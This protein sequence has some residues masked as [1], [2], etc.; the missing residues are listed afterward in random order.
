M[1]NICLKEK[2]NS[3][4]INE[5]DSNDLNLDL[6]ETLKEGKWIS[7]LSTY[8]NGRKSK[9]MHTNRQENSSINLINND[10]KRVN[11]QT[12]SKEYNNSKELCIKPIKFN[13]VNI[14]DKLSGS[15][16]KNSNEGKKIDNGKS[17]SI[18][19][20]KRIQD[21][22]DFNLKIALDNSI[23]NVSLYNNRTDV[24]KNENFNTLYIKKNLK[25]KNPHENKSLLNNSEVKNN[26]IKANVEEYFIKENINNDILSYNTKFIDINLDKDDNNFGLNKVISNIDPFDKNIR[27]NIEKNEALNLNMSNKI[28]GNME[29]FNYKNNKDFLDNEVENL[30]L[31]NIALKNTKDN[32]LL[33]ENMNK[34]KNVRNNGVLKTKTLTNIPLTSSIGLKFNKNIGV[35]NS[36]NVDKIIVKYNTSQSDKINKTRNN[37]LDSIKNFLDADSICNM[38]KVS[39]SN[40]NNIGFIKK[41]FETDNMMFFD[42]IQTESNRNIVIKNQKSDSEMNSNEEFKEQNSSNERN[43]KMSNNKNFTNMFSKNN[44]ERYQDISS[45]NYDYKPAITEDNYRSNNNS[46]NNFIGI[47]RISNK[48]SNYKDQ[49]S[50]S[51]FEANDQN[52]NINN[53]SDEIRRV[54]D[55]EN[56]NLNFINNKNSDKIIHHQKQTS[57]NLAKDK[58]NLDYTKMLNIKNL[59]LE[60]ECL[61]NANLSYCKARP[62]KNLTNNVESEF[63]IKKDERK[64]K[65]INF[66]NYK[67]I[68]VENNPFKRSKESNFTMKEERDLISPKTP[69]LSASEIKFHKFSFDNKN[70]IMKYSKNKVFHKQIIKK[71]LMLNNSKIDKI[72]NQRISNDKDEIDFNEKNESFK[73]MEIKKKSYLNLGQSNSNENDLIKHNKVD[74]YIYNKN[75][76]NNASLELFKKDD[77]NKIH[78]KKL[79]HRSIDISKLNGIK[80]KNSNNV[81]S[82]DKNKLNINEKDFKENAIKKVRLNS[83]NTPIMQNVKSKFNNKHNDNFNNVNAFSIQNTDYSVIRNGTK[84]SESNLIKNSNIQ[85]ILQNISVQLNEMKS[86]FNNFII[87]NKNSGKMINYEFENE[88]SDNND[89]TTNSD[90]KNHLKKD[91][92]SRLNLDLAQNY[93]LKDNLMIHNIKKTFVDNKSKN[94]QF[95]SKNKLSLYTKPIFGN[96]LNETYTYRK[97]L[98]NSDIAFQLNQTIDFNNDNYMKTD[99]NDFEINSSRLF[100][101][102]NASFCFKENRN[103]SSKKNEKNQIIANENLNNKL[104]HCYNIVFN[105]FKEIIVKQVLKAPFNMIKKRKLRN[106]Y[107]SVKILQKVFIRRKY[108]YLLKFWKKCK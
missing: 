25:S 101:V 41:Q 2:L 38:F 34:V 50:F 96:N 30:K 86:N 44:I 100:L 43:F 85:D 26:V 102:K 10:K 15:E 76:D 81:K 107:F 72:Q 108:F 95:H 94:T 66:S 62:T 8:E 28:E 18:I 88:L 46:D 12:I 103:L 104:N 64:D 33:L 67:K 48:Q 98:N 53:N 71:E 97:N 37:K 52:D 27:K 6:T 89:I 99:I 70:E 77:K 24:D 58:S 60:S 22:C 39:K 31:K 11:K 54:E 4:T 17:E 68:N 51:E 80:Y 36:D 74:N 63:I 91:N 29:V 106:I 92:E 59:V 75:F 14:N 1:Q 23:G 13:N 45:I 65:I 3:A 55:N 78:S 7:T 57:N 82:T 90:I 56:V 69:T 84:Q 42:D 9:K 73:N 40:K 32:N 19:L 47:S 16:Q 5:S 105:L 61:Y 79:I 20:S 93:I 21:S 83:D 87:N 49:L 35:L